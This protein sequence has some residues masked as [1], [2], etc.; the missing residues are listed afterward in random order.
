MRKAPVGA[1]GVAVLLAV[2]LGGAAVA[3]AA[4]LPSTPLITYNMQ[5]ANAG[6]DSKWTTTIGN[7]ARAAEIVTLQEVGPW[8]P[9][10]NITVTPTIG[11]TRWRYQHESYEIYFLQTDPNGGTNQGG[12]VNL[13]IL[14]QRPADEVVEVPN[15]VAAGRNALGVRFGSD[16]YFTAHALSG[17]GGD[18]ARLTQAVADFVNNRGL[19]EQWTVSGDFNRRPEDLVVPAGGTI[20]R[21]GQATHQSG[22]EL[23]YAVSSMRLP[24]IGVQRVRGASADHYGVAFGTMRASAEP[25]ELFTSPRVF[26]NVQSGGV[27]DALDQHT[28][29]GTPIVTFR[30]TGNANQVWKPE[31][32]NDGSMR[33]RLGDGRCMEPFLDHRGRYH[34]QLADCSDTDLLQRFVLNSVGDEQ[35]LLWSQ[36]LGRCLDVGLQQEP[37]QQDL[38]L[39][40]CLA[41]HPGQHWLLTPTSHPDTEWDVDRN[42][43]PVSYL[44]SGLA[45][46]ANN[47][48]INGG[49]GFG[50]GLAVTTPHRSRVYPNPQLLTFDW[51]DSGA[52]MIR[53]AP[54]GNC[55]AE[56][57]AGGTP[58]SEVSMVPCN[59]EDLYQQWA[60]WQVGENEFQLRGIPDPGDPV[61][62]HNDEL[63]P[64]EVSVLIASSCT[65]DLP[66]MKWFFAPANTTH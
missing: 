15:P 29:A 19:G 23:D 21:S 48:L 6:S 65:E 58:S 18:A 33:I 43:M 25:H 34:T 14:T 3:E 26:E 64:P 56:E 13:A 9:G 41:G 47:Q 51:L 37:E 42:K 31:F 24:G 50:V 1:C 66:S 10:Q 62:L 32:Y 38:Q 63:D 7:Y 49:E 30:R 20:Y 4:P 27:L 61:C 54:T 16:W 11:H 45:N 35:Y 46:S 40:P 17:G 8:P 52:L 5:G 59:T 44:Y 60:V 53:Y 22:R 57:N 2:T 55:V 39:L 28:E 36:Q 12:R